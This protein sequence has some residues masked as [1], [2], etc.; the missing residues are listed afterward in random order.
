MY[1]CLFFIRTMDSDTYY[2]LFD[3]NNFSTGPDVWMDSVS[4]IDQS[5]Y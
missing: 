4:E 2:N 1:S 5:E 3:R